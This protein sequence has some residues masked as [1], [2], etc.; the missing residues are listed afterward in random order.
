MMK[1]RTALL[2]LLLLLLVLTLG[3]GTADYKYKIYVDSGG[4]RNYIMYADSFNID[5]YGF[6]TVSNPRVRW[7]SHVSRA[8]C[9]PGTYYILE[10]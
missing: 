4:V 1:K 3:C 2:C 10:R 8:I 5:Q 9:A 7:E 6:L